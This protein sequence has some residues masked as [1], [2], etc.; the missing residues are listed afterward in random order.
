MTA[1]E[2]CRFPHVARLVVRLCVMLIVTV[3]AFQYSGAADSSGHRQALIKER[4]ATV[5]PFDLNLT[6]HTN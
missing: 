6:T 2:P 1:G 4:G 5:T 3:G